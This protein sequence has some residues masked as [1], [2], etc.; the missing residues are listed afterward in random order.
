ME[1]QTLNVNNI[2][3]TLYSNSNVFGDYTHESTIS[4]LDL[5]SKCDFNNKKVL[6][7]GT[8]TG[9]LSIFSAL[10]GAAEVTAVDL[11]PYA[12]EVARKNAETNGVENVVS[13]KFNDLTQD[14]EEKFDI[15]LANLPVPP[16]VENV[17]TI[18][19]FLN[20]NGILILSW[21]NHLPFD[22]YCPHFKVIEHI[23]NREY[24]VYRLNA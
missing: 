8:G 14:M 10:S 24:D 9:I 1:K 16:Q 17:K 4:M 20:E 18:K 7:L 23:P 2:E 19:N 13:V 22:I 15:I 12:L 11:N 5:M 3:F 21:V 6:D